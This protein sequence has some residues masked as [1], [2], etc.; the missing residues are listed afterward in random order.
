MFSYNNR[1]CASC[2]V[3]ITAVGFIVGIIGTVLYFVEM[4]RTIVILMGNVL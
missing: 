1:K 3:A 4:H 2:S